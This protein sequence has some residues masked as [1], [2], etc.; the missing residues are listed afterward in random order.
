M[1]QKMSRRAALF[2]VGATVGSALVAGAQPAQAATAAEIDANVE[3]AL[4]ELFR[5]EPGAVELYNQA[6]GTLVIPRVVKGSF[7]A[8]GA[9]GEGKLIIGGI[10]NSYWSYGAASFGFQAGVQ[11]TR[12]AIFFLTQ[13]SLERFAASDS[14]EVGVDAEVTVL[15]I[16][17][18][19]AIDTTESRKPIIAIVFDR[20]GLLGGASLQGG[21][22]GR[23]IR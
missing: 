11:V 23:I 15:E 18:E 5:T 4:Q 8:G 10:T 14:F 9:Y 19:A 16:G 21:R 6:A 3:F 2:G 13:D 20:R 7:I 1:S 17:A 12:Q 22:Y